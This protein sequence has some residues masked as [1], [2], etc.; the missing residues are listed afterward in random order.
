MIKIGIVCDKGKIKEKIELSKNCSM[1]DIS[2]IYFRLN[3]ILR[4][5]LNLEP[6]NRF[7][8]KKEL[9]DEDGTE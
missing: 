9:G 3:A 7:I 2:I 8:I 4:D 1:K 5:I 6:E